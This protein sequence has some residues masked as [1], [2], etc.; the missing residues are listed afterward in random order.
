MKWPST[1]PEYRALATDCQRGKF[2]AH[3]IPTTLALF[4]QP[5][6]VVMLRNNIENKHSRFW[7]CAAVSEYLLEAKK[8]GRSLHCSKDQSIN[9]H[10]P[11][12]CLKRLPTRRELKDHPAQGQELPSGTGNSQCEE[13]VGGDRF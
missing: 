7:E 12:A 2:G 4:G 9:G 5:F 11:G 6:L 13:A 1:G 8:T 3:V 10:D